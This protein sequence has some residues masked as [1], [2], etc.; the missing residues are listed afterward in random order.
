MIKEAA[1]REKEALK[2]EEQRADGAHASAP[3][4]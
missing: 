3:I 4:C 1:K 2:R